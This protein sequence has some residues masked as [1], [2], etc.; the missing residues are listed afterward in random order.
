MRIVVASLAATVIVLGLH[1]PHG[2]WIIW[3]IVQV[4]SEDAGASIIKGVQRIVATLVGGLVGMLIGIAFADEPQFMFVAI[5]VVVAVCMFLTRT[6]SAPDAGLL[7][8]FTMLLVVTSRLDA[9]DAQVDT[10]L[11]RVLMIL[12]G[13]VLGTGAQLVLWPRDPERSLL[14]EVGQ[15]LA[16]VEGLLA[17]AATATPGSPDPRGRPDLVA[18]SGLARELDLLANAEARYPSLR[19]RHTEQI[20]LVTETERLL[21]N[22]L[23]LAE[24]LEDPRYPYRVDDGL[25][26]RLTAMAAACAHLR[27]ALAARR[28]IGPD[29]V[30][31]PFDGPTDLGPGLP[32][33][34][35]TMESTL[36]RIA[37]ATGFLSS[38]GAGA[39][40][41]LPRRSPLDSPA[42]APILTPAFSLSN[43]ADMKF[44]LKC[45]LAVEICLL[46][47]LG[48]DWPGLLTAGVTCLLVAQSTLGASVYKSL[49]RLAGAALGGLLG[50]IVILAVMP[51][52]ES[53]AWLLP[54]FAVCFW[55]GAWLMAGSS[56]ISYV[57]LQTGYAF[58]IAT[59]AAF[60]PTTDLA[61]PGNRILGVLLGIVVMGLVYHWVWP[62]RASRAM[63]P[64]LAVALRAMALLAEVERARGGYASEVSR[65]ARHRVAVYRA[66]ATVLRLREDS[67][68]EPGAAAPAARAE[69]A[70]ILDLTGDAQG[71][72]LALLALARHRLETRATS[73]PVEAAAPLAEFDRS[74][75]HTLERI[76]DALEGKATASLPDMRGSLAAL[77]RVESELSSAPSSHAD[78]PLLTHLGREVTIR[79]YVLGH[80]DRLA[81][82]VLHSH[83]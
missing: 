78:A 42:R 48:L 55:I 30:P 4:S 28:P 35:A 71:V 51:N 68:L 69:R 2:D 63:R 58:G 29:D 17:R 47:P 31:Y 60:G 56:Q 50:L 19:R 24:S 64:A 61:P 80:V 7:V 77:E 73:V 41:L 1:A 14:D 49:L 9:P 38:P 40:R 23:W 44:A 52:V 39:L 65:A 53:L 6:T 3:T 46:I 59:L 66:L 33:L 27:G 67:V 34:V 43:T 15:R 75:R 82:Q 70:L 45:A 8:A 54:P 21:T 18:V 37:A 83:A 12:V 26:A 76:A 62:V 36:A 32:T 13:V 5:G 79:R 16:R 11:W 72:F 20:A 57:G 74:V 81:R 25:R 10:A 22:A